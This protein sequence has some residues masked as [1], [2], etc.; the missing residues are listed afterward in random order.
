MPFVNAKLE[1]LLFDHSADLSDA[2]RVFNSEMKRT[3]GTHCESLEAAQEKVETA[4]IEAVREVIKRFND[5]RGVEAVPPS[6][7]FDHF[8]ESVKRGPNA[9]TEFASPSDLESLKDLCK[10]IIA[11]LPAEVHKL[12]VARNG[13][14]LKYVEEQ[15]RAVCSSAVRHDGLSLQFV[16]KQTP[17]LCRDAVWR[18]GLALQFVKEQTAEICLIAVKQN[19][20]A[21]EF[22]KEQTAEICDEA[23]KQN[24]LASKFIR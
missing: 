22:V 10:K 11:S 20:L 24:A 7:D 8:L 5:E 12:A 14:V 9:A 1:S 18:N 15:T 19:G 17:K 6:D 3:G 2:L 4:T 21:L 13:T 16:K 23:V